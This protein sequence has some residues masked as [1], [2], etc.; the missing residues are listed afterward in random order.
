MGE[1]FSDRYNYGAAEPE[2]SVREDAP[3]NLRYAVAQIA[4]D[5]GMSPKTLRAVV[6]AVLYVAPDE[7]NNWSDYPNV[8]GEIRGL[9]DDCPWY[10][11]YDI[12]EAIN[13]RLAE[14]YDGA[15]ERFRT[16]LDRFFREQGIGWS[17][18]SDGITFRGGDSFQALTAQ[19]SQTLAE[20]GRANAAREI[21]EAI[22]DI[23]RRPKPDITGAIQHA[24][25]A[26]ESTARD[27]VGSKETLGGLVSALNLPKP[28][29]IAVEKLWGYSSNWARHIQEGQQL[30]ANHAE[31]LVGVACAVCTFLAKTS[32]PR[33]AI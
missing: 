18:G 5:C 15:A 2:I 33:R 19:A 16:A 17:F 12:A 14:R 24:M 26:V 21:H 7:R 6:C 25:T 13:Q 27:V 29:D 10:K 9:L 11:V 23:S 22:R 31:L 30:D 8:W 32:P 4:V 28:L 20:S 3:E 1:R